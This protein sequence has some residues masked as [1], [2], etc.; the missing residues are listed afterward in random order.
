[1]VQQYI[2]C[3][4]FNSVIIQS[5]ISYLHLKI[6][7]V[8]EVCNRGNLTI[9]LI[10]SVLWN[11]DVTGALIKKRCIFILHDLCSALVI[12][13]EVSCYLRRLPTVQ[14]IFGHLGNT[15]A[16]INMSYFFQLDMKI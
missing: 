13:F 14:P 15:S 12:S 10:F 11:R 1:M 2:G 8:L 9:E 7:P 16:L 5:Y 4:I 3:Q 6:V